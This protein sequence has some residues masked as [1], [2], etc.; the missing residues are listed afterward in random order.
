M[1]SDEQLRILMIKFNN[2]LSDVPLKGKILNTK[3]RRS[4]ISGFEF[5]FW[6]LYIWRWFL[7]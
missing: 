4:N 1:Q 6:I 7:V 2:K 5:G 3:L